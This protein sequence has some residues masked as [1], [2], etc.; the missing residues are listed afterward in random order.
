MPL[1][2]RNRGGVILLEAL[3]A[4]TLVSVSALA[5]LALLR[6]DAEDA[7]RL[8]ER[9]REMHAASDFLEAASLWTRPE[10]DARLGT[11][12]QGPYMLRILRPMSTLYTLELLDAD[13]DRRLLA[14]AIFR[15]EEIRVAP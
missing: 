7:S 11:R 2:A 6:A 13:H 12:Q 4:L 15:P 14:T 5:T 1:L 10:L 8:L 9:S 3:V